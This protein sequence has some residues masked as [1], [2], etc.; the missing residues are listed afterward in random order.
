MGVLD[1][2]YDG[3]FGGTSFVELYEGLAAVEPDTGGESSVT[4][5]PGG[6]TTVIQTAGLVAKTLDLSIGANTAELRALEG[7]V[8]SRATLVYHAGSV[9]ARLMKVKNLRYVYSSGSYAAVLELII[10]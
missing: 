6:N 10:G 8:L 4:H 1:T 3:S 5:I 2:Y 9:N 7:K